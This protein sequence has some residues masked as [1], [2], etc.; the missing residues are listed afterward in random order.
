VTVGAKHHLSI[1]LG[2][3]GEAKRARR[4][5]LLKDKREQL[6]SVGAGDVLDGYAVGWLPAPVDVP[7]QHALSAPA[8]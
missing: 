2:Q 6:G 1:V 8:L 7:A 3:T 5:Q 4:L